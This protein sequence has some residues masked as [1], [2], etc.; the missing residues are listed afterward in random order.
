ME[1]CLF[2]LSSEKQIWWV[3]DDNLEIIFQISP[4]KYLLWILII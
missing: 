3:F 2:D 4:Y 1:F